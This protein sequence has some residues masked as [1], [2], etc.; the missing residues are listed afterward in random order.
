MVLLPSARL[1]PMPLTVDG[2]ITVDD[3]VPQVISWLAVPP[4][5]ADG[6]GASGWV[7]V[8]VVVGT[9]AT[10]VASAAMASAVALARW[11]RTAPRVPALA[12]WS[13]VVALGCFAL[14]AALAIVIV[15]TG[16]RV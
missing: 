1:E 11:R 5:E 8:P 14:A 7:R 15:S 2:A 10:L 6:T 9:A 16:P 4:T 13:A 12:S 3:D